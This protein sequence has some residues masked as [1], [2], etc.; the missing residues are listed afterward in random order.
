[1]DDI[2]SV[3]SECCGSG[4]TNCVLDQRSKKQTALDNFDGPNVLSGGRY[5]QFRCTRIE[6]ITTNTY[7][8]R[9]HLITNDAAEDAKLLIPPGSHLMLRAERSWREA[10]R[11]LNSVFSKWCNEALQTGA[12]RSRADRRA[13]PL[14]EKHDKTERD[15]YFSRPYTPISVNQTE[16][17]FDVLIKLEV[18]GEMSEYLVTLNI[19]DVAEW[20]G[21]Y[22]GFYWTRN[23][24]SHLVGFVQGVGIAPVYSIMK[25]ILQDEE[26]YTKL[27]L[28]SCF[29]DISGITLRSDLYTMTGFWNFESTIYLSRE[30]CKCGDRRSCSCLSSRKK[31]NE[32]IFNHRLETIDI[33]NLLQKYA[34]SS[35]QVLICGT[36]VFVAFIECCISKINVSYNCYKF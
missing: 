2:E 27:C 4:C 3:T 23:M 30:P 6:P 28:C 1:M 18:D 5:H 33:E 19:G 25:N 15:L 34:S 11:P 35:V 10:S 21:V 22:T 7:L 31:Y 29:S 8:F 24:C 36:D 17:T 12:H 13:R 9:F 26:D 32:R 16:R 14:V 20:K